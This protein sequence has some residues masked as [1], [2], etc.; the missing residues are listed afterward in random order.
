M[1]LNEIASNNSTF[2][3]RKE[4]NHGGNMGDFSWV[5]TELSERFPYANPNVGF[6]LNGNGK[7]EKIEKIKDFNRDGGIDSKDW[8]QYYQNNKPQLIRL[9]GIFAWAKDFNPHNP[10]HDYVQIMQHVSLPQA[11]EIFYQGLEYLGKTSQEYQAQGVYDNMVVQR[12]FVALKIFQGVSEA[13][14]GDNAIMNMWNGAIDCD[15]ASIIAQ[16]HLYEQH[17]V[18]HLVFMP[19]HVLLRHDL[20]NHY[21]NYD[22]TIVHGKPNEVYQRTE[23][24]SDTLVQGGYYLNSTTREQAI[25][26]FLMHRASLQ[27]QE[28]NF[29]AARQSVELAIDEDAMNVSAYATLGFFAL[30]QGDLATVVQVEKIMQQFP[31]EHPARLGFEMKVAWKQSGVGAFLPKLE[32]YEALY[33]LHSDY[34]PSEEIR[35]QL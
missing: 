29:A 11:S 21:I 17:V 22:F 5:R 1:R 16:A 33:G 7:L 25:S 34:F 15:T 9:G 18:T 19:T 31:Q 4:S 24:L 3:T 14:H 2:K 32:A 35:K 12:A 13:E 10:I 6:D 28:G 30:E 20:G 26:L 27:Y 23:H 8:V